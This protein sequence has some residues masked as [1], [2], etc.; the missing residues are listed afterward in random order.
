MVQTLSWLREIKY[1]VIV[2]SSFSE[3]LGVLV[4]LNLLVGGPWLVTSQEICGVFNGYPT[5]PHG[6]DIVCYLDIYL[7]RTKT[8]HM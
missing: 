7:A 3:S 6:L 2:F 4:D 8:G 1:Q 5:A